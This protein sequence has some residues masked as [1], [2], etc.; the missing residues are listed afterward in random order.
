VPDEPNVKV[1]PHGLSHEFPNGPPT[2][3]IAHRGCRLVLRF[4]EGDYAGEGQ[5]QA[6]E[7]HPD[8]ETLEPRVL[9]RFSPQAELYVAYARAAMR[10]FGPEGTPESRRDNL[11]GAAEALR[12]IGGPGRGLSDEFFRTI[13]KHYD[14]IVSEGEPHPVKALGEAHSVTIGAAS[15]WI[16]EARRRGFITRRRREPRVPA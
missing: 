12:Q 1:F 10:V 7:L 5:L 2:A 9:R 11:R 4:G 13:A 14:A 8:A 6:L 3:V 16:K 15:R